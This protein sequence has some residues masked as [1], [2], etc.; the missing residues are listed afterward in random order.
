MRFK[1]TLICALALA[2]LAAQAPQP[3]PP[4]QPP[5]FRAEA[6]LVRVDVTVVDRHGEPV[7]TLAADDFAV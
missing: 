1:I 5:T 7:A 2:S 6:N 3:T 4:A